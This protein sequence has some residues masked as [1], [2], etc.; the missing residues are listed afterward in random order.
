[1]GNFEPIWHLSH[2]LWWTS[3]CIRTNPGRRDGP[4]GWCSWNCLRLVL[5][6][7]ME[8]GW[9]Y[10]LEWP[11]TQPSSHPSLWVPLNSFQADRSIAS[12]LQ[13][14][15]STHS[16]YHCVSERCLSLH[17]SLLRWVDWGFRR[18]KR[19]LWLIVSI[20][21]SWWTHSAGWPSS[22]WGLHD[23]DLLGW[24]LCFLPPSQELFPMCT[25]L[26]LSLLQCLPEWGYR[27]PWWNYSSSADH[28]L[29]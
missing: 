7:L 25:L 13:I 1:M 21:C 18:W 6:H 24:F 8:G 12:S 22:C 16:Q 29:Q 11:S 5:Q 2:T 26:E 19:M 14:I 17:P 15:Y 4:D 28:L 9:R 23:S 20:A 10:L 27:P 3:L